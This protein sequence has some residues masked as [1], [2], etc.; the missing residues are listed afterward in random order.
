MG[1]NNT[2]THTAGVGIRV[3]RGHSTVGGTAQLCTREG[4][5]DAP[6]HKVAEHLDGPLCVLQREDV[7]E[8]AGSDAG[9]CCELCAARWT[10]G[11]DDI[12]GR[13]RDSADRRPVA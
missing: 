9:E 12:R 1:P 3:A 8:T 10:K 2:T 5:E 13:G 6:V 11:A 4:R 7:V